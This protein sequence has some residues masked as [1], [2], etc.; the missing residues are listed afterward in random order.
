VVT[1]INCNL[2]NSNKNK[3]NKHV[4]LLVF[5]VVVG[6]LVLFVCL[7]VSLFVDMRVLTEERR[8]RDVVG[9]PSL[10]ALNT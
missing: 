8:P 1:H 6:W 4:F 2:G 9:Y 3:K 7:F 5:F 10:E